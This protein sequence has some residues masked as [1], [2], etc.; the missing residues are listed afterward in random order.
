MVTVVRRNTTDSIDRSP[1]VAQYESRFAVPIHEAHPT[2]IVVKCPVCRDL[3]CVREWLKNL[4][5]CG[6]CGYHFRLSAFERIQQLLDPGSFEELARELH[7]IDPL[8][9]A[10]LSQSYQEKLECERASTALSEAVVIGYGRIADLPLFVAVMDFRFMGGSMGSVV[11]EK[12]TRVI[13]CAAEERIPLLIISA[14]GGARMQEGL[15]SLM[16]MAKTSSALGR[17][18]D[19]G[20]PFISLLTD[21][22]TGG[23]AASFAFLGDVILAEPGALIGFAGPRVIE[24]FMHQQLPEGTNTSEFVLQHGMIDGLVH[25][26][27][28]RTTLVRLLRLYGGVLEPPCSTSHTGSDNEFR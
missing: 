21:P 8:H 14:S 2:A 5:T 4:K 18:A 22:T 13:E 19:A 12:I 28:L 11:G 7:S 23:V 25:R 26:Q 6:N 24:Q 15:F 10:G 17:L 20:V 9:F 16:Q 1:A 27:A 3:L